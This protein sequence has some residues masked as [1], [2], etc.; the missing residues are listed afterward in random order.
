MAKTEPWFRTA[1]R[2]G[3]T[4]LVEI[5]PARYDDAW[6][7][8]YWRDTRIDGVI[9][10]AGGIVAYYPSA[11]PLHH[12]AVTL[13]GR[14]LYG[15]IVRS[16]REE[17][18]CVI[19][20]MDSNRVAEDFY[21]AH[22]DWICVD[23]EGE[24]YRSADK[25]ITCVNGPYYHEYLPEVMRE[26]IKR[27]S[28][29]GITDNS[30][31]GLARDKICFCTHCS[32]G[33]T[34][35][36][37]LPLPRRADWRNEAYRQWIAWNY[38]R[39]TEIWDQNNT[40]TTEAGGEH[41]LW[42]GMIGGDMLNHSA[43]FIDVREILSRAETVLLDHQHRNA[44]EGFE[45]NSEVGKRLHEL[46]GWDKMIPESTPMYQLGQPS[47]RLAAMPSA[48]VRLWSSHAFAG[49]IQPWW[50]HVGSSHEDRRQYGTA[51]PIFLWHEAN[52]SILTNRTPQANVGVVWSQTNNDFYGQD[53]PAARTLD[54]YRG[55]V[56]SLVDAAIPFVPVH[57]DDIGRAAGRFDALVLPNIAAMSKETRNAIRAFSRCGAVIATGETSL[58]DEVG[59][60]LA[61]FGLADLFGVHATDLYH[62]GQSVANPDIETSE[63]HSYLRLHPDL[64]SDACGRHDGTAEAS[65]MPRHA[66]LDGFGKTDS[67]PFGGYLQEIEVDEGAA[68]LLT[69]IPPF[70]IFPPETAWMRH[71]ST[72]IPGLVVRE[73]ESGTK[74]AMLAADLDRCTARDHQPDHMRIIANLV[75]WAIGDKPVLLVESEGRISC[76]V[77]EQ[78]LRQIVHLGNTTTTSETPAR[79]NRLIPLGPIRVRLP[80]RGSNAPEWVSLRVSGREVPTSVDAHYLDFVVERL[81]D[82]EVAVV[83]WGA[84]RAGSKSAR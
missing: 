10:N 41:C 63:R 4:N 47:F 12:R 65:N 59:D 2:W 17:G 55:V 42:L 44:T 67:I 62:G 81:L 22:P 75:R 32:A 69:F 18:L 15:D 61:D 46:L 70:P 52:Q 39:R 74:V 6:W 80:L 78:D 71:S 54:P 7:R 66:A 73:S 19:A 30:W 31:A 20:R 72:R 60:R 50:H 35:S 5:D 49:G 23:A 25:F 36:T 45:Q 56:Q 40:V 51:A 53:N 37:G 8:Q 16:A 13:K 28:P 48:E 3:Q 9:V 11:F 29:D 21:R 14:D 84:G 79:Q 27:S 26:I 38:R 33:F 83:D 34:E 58:Y 24:P 76:N 1:L 43:R 77:Y 82:H 64:G 57:V 68:I